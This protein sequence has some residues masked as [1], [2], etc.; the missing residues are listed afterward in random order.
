MLRDAFLAEA[1]LI[2]LKIG[3]P[4][5]FP[6]QPDGIW[7]SPYNGEQ[8]MP[9]KGGDAYRRGLYTFWKRTAPYPSFMA[10]DAGSREVCVS[11]RERTNTPLQALTLLN[12]QAFL[13]A[14]RGLSKRMMAVGPAAKRVAVGFRLATSRAPSASESD[15]LVRLAKSLEAKYARDPGL[16]KKL[17]GS[18]S[19]AAW[20]LVAS[21]IL[22]LDEAVTKG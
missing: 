18:P 13:E 6:H 15:R 12:D 7:N 11:R 20:M 1:G 16:A 17:A 3:G 9:S 8:W 22:N 5:V 4:S 10:L 2:N 14:A 19:E 21:T